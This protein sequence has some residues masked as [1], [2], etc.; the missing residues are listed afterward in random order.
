VELVW[1]TSWGHQANKEISPALGLPQLPVIDVKPATAT[2]G[3]PRPLVW[4][5]DMF[6]EVTHPKLQ[7][8]LAGRPHMI[9]GPDPHVG[10]T[11]RHI[12]EIHYWI[13]GH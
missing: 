12:L 8:A 10:L 7:E 5:D 2:W 13:G 11:Y 4:I 1:S 6:H 9:V 3:S